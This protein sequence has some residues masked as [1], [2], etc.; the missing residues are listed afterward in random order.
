MATIPSTMTTIEIS[1]PG[2]PQVLKAV[3]RKIP[4]V[5]PG[6]VLIEVAAAGI[7]R[8]DCLQRE[9]LY[10][11]PKGASDIPGLEISGTIVNVGDVDARHSIGDKVMALVTGGGYSEYCIAE[12]ECVL[13]VPAGI[14]MVEA[15]AIPE[16]F[17]TV[18]HNVFQRAHLVEGET[19]LVHGGTSG[20]GTTAIQLAKHFGAKV[21][22]TAGSEDKC[23]ASIELG[24]DG[25]INYREQDFVA[26]VDKFTD[27][28]G[29]DVIL[30]M[31]GGSYT[32]RNYSAAAMD[33]R[34]VQIAFLGGSKVQVDFMP[35]MLKRLVHTGSTMRARSVEFKGIIARELENQVWPLIEAGKVK[36][37]IDKVYALNEA[38]EAHERIED[39]AHIGKIV[40]QVKSPSE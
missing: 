21:I 23:K 1:K 28:K 11:P 12:K 27:G 39:S 31:V 24:A 15:A 18:W 19:L 40:L 26:Q 16:T 17:F 25:A 29:A 4:S 32:Q 20:I 22:I 8:P 2:G 38:A 30:D 10:P 33:G 7:N 3:E 36:P 5:G 34:I 35:L 13:A 9:G 37:V 6:Q 14:S